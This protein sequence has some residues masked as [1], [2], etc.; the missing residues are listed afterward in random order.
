M[1]QRRTNLIEGGD[2]PGADAAHAP[3]VGHLFAQA[4]INLSGEGATSRTSVEQGADAT[5]RIDQ[6]ATARLGWVSGKNG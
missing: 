5:E 2:A 4:Q 1:H 3:E 6:R